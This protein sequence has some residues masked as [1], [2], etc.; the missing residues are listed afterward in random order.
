MLSLLL[1]AAFPIGVTADLKPIH[2]TLTADAF[3]YSTKRTRVVFAGVPPA[4]LDARQFVVAHLES[5]PQSAYPPP[6]TAYAGGNAAEHYVWR[7]LAMHAPDLVVTS[8]PE[9]AAALPSIGIPVADK[10][11]VREPSAA[12]REIQRRLARSPRETALALAAHYG[13][14]LPE[15][16]Y[17]PA[18]ALI[19]RL[20]LGETSDVARIV[21]PYLEAQPSLPAKITGSHLSGHL[22]F[23]ELARATGDKRYAALVRRAADLAFDPEGRPLEAMPSHSEM[24]DAVFMGTP[25]LAEAGRLSGE[26]RYFDMALRHLRFM[27]KLNLRADGLH[28]HSPLDETAWGRGNGFPALGLTWTVDALPASYSGRAEALQALRRHLEALLPHQDASG[29]W[30]QIID[31]PGSY[32]E[33]TATAM[34]GYA[35]L[36]GVRAGWLDRARFLPAVRRAWDAV[37]A[38]V[39]GDGALFDV[40]T[41]TGKQKSERD[42]YERPAIWGKDD[43][44]GAMAL[45]FATEMMRE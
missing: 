10:A 20:R 22:V 12:R 36:R 19:G 17:I 34:I 39:A 4:R 21:A 30:H 8:S 41:G 42:Y 38:R 2:A 27:L 15:V 16:V 29:A 26:T 7:F 23:A 40:C 9:L 13:H 11:E 35:M 44:G 45:L 28:R 1:A 3:D 6:G 37:N 18:V 32:R 31:R 5:V 14:K 24:S 43:R 33:L 25:I